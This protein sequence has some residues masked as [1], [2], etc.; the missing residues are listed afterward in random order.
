MFTV[1]NINVHFYII[2]VV[3]K[4]VLFDVKLLNYMYTPQSYHVVVKL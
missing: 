1:Q 3:S 4:D 2:C